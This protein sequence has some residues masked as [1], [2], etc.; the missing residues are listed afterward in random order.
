MLFLWSKAVQ[1]YKLT[2]KTLYKIKKLECW[3]SDL[4]NNTYHSPFLPKDTPKYYTKPFS[5]SLGNHHWFQCYFSGKSSS[6]S[7]IKTALLSHGEKHMSILN[8]GWCS[9]LI[10]QESLVLPVNQTRCGSRSITEA[11]RSLLMYT[12]TTTTSPV[13]K[14]P[15]RRVFFQC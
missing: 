12:T 2:W 6:F 13:S 4:W 3:I 10:Q 8:V 15:L 9:P 1:E 7:R 11:L 14:N 5:H